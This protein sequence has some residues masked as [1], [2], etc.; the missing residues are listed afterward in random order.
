MLYQPKTY[1]ELMGQAYDVALRRVYHG[2]LA[3]RGHLYRL[4]FHRYS[5]LFSSGLFVE[6]ISVTTLTVSGS[7]K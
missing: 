2:S 6:Y 5:L 3:A 4:G 7:R 1:L